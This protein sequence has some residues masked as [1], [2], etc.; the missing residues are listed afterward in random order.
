MCTVVMHVVK[1]KGHFKATL[2]RTG[3]EV[4]ATVFCQNIVSHL[5]DGRHGGIDKNVIKPDSAR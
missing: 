2:R 5:H 1:I 4:Q 3:E